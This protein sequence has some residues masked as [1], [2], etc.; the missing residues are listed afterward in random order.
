MSASRMASI[1]LTYVLL[2]VGATPF[3]LASLYYVLNNLQR[4]GT[5]P[6]VTLLVGSLVWLLS[7]LSLELAPTFEM[8]LWANRIQYIGIT[9][10]PLGFVLFALAY[11]DRDDLVNGKS[12]ILLSLEPIAV[13]ALVFTNTSHDLWTTAVVGEGEQYVVGG[14]QT[15]CDAVICWGASGP[16]FLAHTFYTYTILLVGAALVLVRALSSDVIPR[17]QAITMSIAVGV[18]L[19]GNI[20]SLFVLPPG[21]PDLTPV[22]FGVMGVA[23]VVGLYRYSLV[24][25]GALTG[26]A[27]IEERENGAILLDDDSVIEVNIEAAAVLGVDADTIVEESAAAAFANHEALQ[28]AHADDPTTVDGETLKAPIS[29]ETY[30]VDVETIDPEGTTQTGWVY[31]FTTED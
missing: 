6:L 10:V 2:L 23:L 31:E 30:R 9:L 4:R 27:A 1:N 11:Y 7:A 14:A 16:G 17:G 13:L 29:G 18:P 12:A 22:M 3:I 15:T 19:V 8:A 28:S 26:T 21:T 5:K 25:T 20:L 24:E